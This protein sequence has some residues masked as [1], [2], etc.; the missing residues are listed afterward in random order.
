MVG[1]AEAIGLPC[2]PVLISG[3][4]GSGRDRGVADGS[5]GRYVGQHRI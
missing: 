1:E 2:V 5:W 4:L 3:A